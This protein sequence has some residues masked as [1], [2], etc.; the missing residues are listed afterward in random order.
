MLNPENLPHAN[1]LRPD[2]QRLWQRLQHEPL[3]AGFVL[4]GGT[5]LTLHLG[6]RLSEDLDFATTTPKLPR[7]QIAQLLRTLAAEGIS[8]ASNDSPA[9]IEEY[10]DSGLELADSQQEYIF[11][12]SVKVMFFSPHENTRRLLRA[13]ARDAPRVAS[14][15][16]I[17]RLKCL[18]SADRSKTRDWFDL[19]CLLRQGHFQPLDIHQAFVLA[20]EP[21]KFDIAMTRLTSG[22]PSLV[23]EGYASL[24]EQAP[25]ID[26]M[27]E[28]FI[29]VQDELQV[30]MA[31]RQG[32]AQR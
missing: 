22:K 14:L 18:V 24:L 11:A 31:R 27:R 32:L 16:E 6:H 21:A 13:G 19:Y 23:D 9:A 2:T 5:A 20:G 17:F 26:D 8:T 3:L 28:Y 29:Q 15:E 30:E 12:G 1:E 10:E 7:A 4:V 25:S